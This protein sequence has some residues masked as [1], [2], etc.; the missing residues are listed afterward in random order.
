MRMDEGFI[1][2]IEVMKQKFC[3]GKKEFVEWKDF[4]NVWRELY[5]K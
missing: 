3:S 2:F 4:V 5:Q 1:L